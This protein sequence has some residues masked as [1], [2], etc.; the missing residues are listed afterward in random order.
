[1]NAFSLLTYTF[2]SSEDGDSMPVDDYDHDDPTMGGFCVI[3]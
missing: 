3:P 1:M 2:L